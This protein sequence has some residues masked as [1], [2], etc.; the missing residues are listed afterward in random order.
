MGIYIC[1]FIQTEKCLA[2]G[3]MAWVSPPTLKLFSGGLMAL[4]SSFFTCNKNAGLR[5]IRM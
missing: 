3:T 5:M 2:D 4:I 1:L